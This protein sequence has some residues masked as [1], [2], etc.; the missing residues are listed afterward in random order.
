MGLRTRGWDDLRSSGVA[1]G[2]RR[3]GMGRPN[4]IGLRRPPRSAAHSEPSPPPRVRRP[5][6]SR[7]PWR[8][9]WAR[10][11]E[12]EEGASWDEAEGENA[13]ESAAFRRR[14]WRAAG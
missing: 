6:G 7:S 10:R 8:G 11:E 9:V 1:E 4:A 3:S 12:D 14:A 5:F 2:Y 13:S